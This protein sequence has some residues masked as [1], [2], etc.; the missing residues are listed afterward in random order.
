[1]VK[2]L[3]SGG[4]NGTHDWQYVFDLNTNTLTKSKT[5]PPTYNVHGRVYNNEK[6]HAVTDGEPRETGYLATIDPTT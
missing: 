1:M 4:S 2:T 3:T 5:H 6:L